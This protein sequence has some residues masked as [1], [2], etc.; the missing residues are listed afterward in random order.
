M[1]HS[2]LPAGDGCNHGEAAGA[3]AGYAFDTG[4]EGDWRDDDDDAYGAPDFTADQQGA[5]EVLYSHAPPLTSLSGRQQ[6]QRQP[7][8][9][10]KDL[11]L[12][13]AGT[14]RGSKGAE[15]VASA[16][17]QSLKRWRADAAVSGGAAAPER[18]P[19]GVSPAHE[20][21]WQ[22]ASQGRHIW[23]AA[24]TPQAGAGD[25]E[26][27]AGNPEAH[28]QPAAQGE[29]RLAD[30]GQSTDAAAMPATFSWQPLASGGETRQQGQLPL[31]PKQPAWSEHDAGAADAQPSSWGREQG[32]LRAAQG[33][34]S[35]NEHLE[36]GPAGTRFQHAADEQAQTS[37]PGVHRRREGA[38]ASG[39]GWSSGPAAGLGAEATLQTWAA[40]DRT[41]PHPLG[42]QQGGASA[43]WPGLGQPDSRAQEAHS[44]HQERAATDWPG[45]GQL[46]SRAHQ[47]QEWRSDRQSQQQKWAAALPCAAGPDAKAGG[48]WHGYSHASEPDAEVAGSLRRLDS[49]AAGPS[50]DQDSLWRQNDSVR[51]EQSQATDWQ[52]AAAAGGKAAL[53]QVKGAQNMDVCCMAGAQVLAARWGFDHVLTAVQADSNRLALALESNPFVESCCCHLQAPS[54]EQPPL[55]GSGAEGPEVQVNASARGAGC[56]QP[57]KVGFGCGTS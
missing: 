47:P 40:A 54:W 52:E 17:L 14:V 6:R 4:Q 53:Q 42:Q 16:P 13:Q 49:S 22:P 30:G 24:G 50:A 27:D 55:Q 46:D 45:L 29:P 34:S 2:T 8:S 39:G 48:G 5:D 12:S 11:A 31:R 7:E 32:M 19:A 56:G 21:P 51:E 38:A 20:D 43:D 9:G 44:Q 3:E 1:Q 57:A 41:A 25:W 37:Q 18:G 23:S 35:Y 15:W 28:P 10:M 33:G 26:A 36:E